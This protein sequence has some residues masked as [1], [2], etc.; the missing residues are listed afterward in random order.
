MTVIIG[1]GPHKASHGSAHRMRRTPAGAETKVRARCRQTEK[2]SAWAKPL[3]PRTWAV[4]SA[5]GMGY[6][7][8]QQFLVGGHRRP[9][10]AGPAL[11]A[12]SPL[13]S[14]DDEQSHRD[15]NPCRHLDPCHHLD[16]AEQFVTRRPCRSH[17]VALPHFKTAAF[18]NR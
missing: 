18:N 17:A 12:D 4:E 1:I 7:L 5:G 15:S 2:L 3:G 9:A 10:L 13:T 11:E 14:H 8:S 16:R 6:L